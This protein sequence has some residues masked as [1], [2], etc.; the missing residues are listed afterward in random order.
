MS[1]PTGKGLTMAIYGSQEAP[2]DYYVTVMYIKYTE[3]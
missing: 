3:R 2:V 1:V